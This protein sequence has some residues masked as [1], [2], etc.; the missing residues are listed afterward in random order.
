MHSGKKSA[1]APRRAAS[2]PV[3]RSAKRWRTAR[4]ARLALYLN[5]TVAD[6]GFRDLFQDVRFRRALSVAINRHEINQVVFFGLALEGNN[7]V[8]PESPLYKPEYQKSWAQFDIETANGLLDE[9]GLTERDDEGI[10]LLPD[11]RP[12]V[13]I[14]ETA[15]ESTEET[16]VLQLIADSW[17]QVGVKLFTKPLQREVFRNRIYAG[18]TQA[19]IWTGLENGLPD[20]GMSPLELAPVRQDSLQWPRWGQYVE[21]KGRSG[22]PADLPAAEELLALYGAWRDTTVPAE[23]ERIWH[24]MLALHADQV[25]TI[26]IVNGIPQPVVVNPRLRNIPEEGLYNWNPGAF[27]GL[28]HPDSFWFAAAESE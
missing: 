23:R 1:H 25:L 7:T 17:A 13:I 9:L 24:D 4:G 19:S 15:G 3:S 8:L 5:L 20:A 14:V 16:D 27:F 22:E 6:P 18:E 11:G 12:L 2:S 10:R 28:Y 21:T 26:G